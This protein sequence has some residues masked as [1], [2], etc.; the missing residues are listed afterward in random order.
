LKIFYKAILEILSYRFLIFWCKIG[1]GAPLGR[2][3]TYK[4]R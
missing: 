3:L 4:P 2:A 1:W